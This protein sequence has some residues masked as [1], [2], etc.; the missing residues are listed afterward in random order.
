VLS[1]PQD[2]E[3]QHSLLPMLTRSGPILSLQAR[4]RAVCP[5]LWSGHPATIGE[6]ALKRT[7]TRYVAFGKGS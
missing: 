7:Q 1:G 4:N 5:F 3:S 2:L 6:A